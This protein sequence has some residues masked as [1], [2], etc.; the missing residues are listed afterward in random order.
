M[1]YMNLHFSYL[2]TK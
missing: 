2:L 1:H